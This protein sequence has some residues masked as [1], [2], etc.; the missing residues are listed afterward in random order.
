MRP[1]YTHGG[2]EEYI[3][4]GIFHPL[5]D[6]FWRFFKC[7]NLYFQM[8]VWTFFTKIKRENQ[9]ESETAKA[10]FE[11]KTLPFL[12][13]F[14]RFGTFLEITT[15]NLG[16]NTRRLYLRL[17]VVTCVSTH[18]YDGKSLKTIIEVQKK[19]ILLRPCVSKYVCLSVSE[20][21]YIF[22]PR[23]NCQNM[24]FSAGI[25]L[26]PPRYTVVI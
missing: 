14:R 8:L 12:P 7:F 24:K 2:P 6:V 19:H 16:G 26:P 3:Y 22:T 18:K 1:K 5:F 11:Q 23:Y 20:G 17:C 13:L 4:E 21:G 10:F 9:K 15:V 25:S